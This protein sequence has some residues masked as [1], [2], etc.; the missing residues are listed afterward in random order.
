MNGKTVAPGSGTAFSSIAFYD[1]RMTPF[2]HWANNTR[3]QV[4]AKRGKI[5]K[6]EAGV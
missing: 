1:G 6:E 3:W 2:A 4:S 5:G